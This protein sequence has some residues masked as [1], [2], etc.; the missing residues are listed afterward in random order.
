MTWLVWLYDMTS[1]SGKMKSNYES[2]YF[3]KRW[4]VSGGAWWYLSRYWVQR[5]DPIIDYILFSKQRNKMLKT[6]LNHLYTFSKIGKI[7]IMVRILFTNVSGTWS[8]CCWAVRGW[9][10]P[11]GRITSAR[12]C[13]SS[14]A[15][16][17]TTRSSRG[18]RRTRTTSRWS[19]WTGSTCWWAA[20][21]PCTS[22]SC[23]TW[24]CASCWSGTPVSR[25]RACAWWRASQR[26]FVR[27]TSKCWKS[28][29]M[30]RV[31][32]WCAAPTP[33]SPSAGSTWR[34]RGPTWWRRRARGWG[35]A[36][37]AP[38]TTPPPSWC[39]TSCTPAPLQTI[40]SVQRQQ[41]ILY[42]SSVVTRNIILNLSF[43][44][45]FCYQESSILNFESKFLSE[46]LRKVE[47]KWLN[48]LFCPFPSKFH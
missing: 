14:P 41:L 5:K 8:G 6:F 23:G 19:W 32:T 1:E 15:S 20:G 48:Q 9:R 27:T 28:S 43:S 3:P 16:T 37:T 44:Q 4:G 13:T 40:R 38:S 11:G 26:P 24:S 22:C 35:C 45:S 12:G 17:R 30:T 29:R 25:T 2:K 39:R 21:T 33:S 31:A 7:G 34:T 36:P 10:G 46:Q 42:Y 18:T 47:G